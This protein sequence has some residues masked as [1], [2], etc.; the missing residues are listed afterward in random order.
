M[1]GARNGPRWKLT[2]ESESGE[3]KLAEAKPA[4]QLDA[5]KASGVANPLSSPSFADV[6][7]SAKPEDLGLDKPTVVTVGT[8]DNFTYT[9]KVGQKTN[10]DFP[11][12]MTV[13]AQFQKERTPGKDEKPEDK[14]KLDKEFKEKQKKLEEK[15]N[16]EKGYE[17]WVYLVSNW[18]VD[19]MLKE[20]AQLLVEKKEEPKKEEKPVASLKPEE[21]KKEEPKGEDKPSTNEPPKKEDQKQDQ[22]PPADP[23]PEPP[24]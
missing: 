14:D 9:L 16:Q 10:D 24:K 5:S 4:E 20:R 13:S 15:L 17:K 18:T 11:L 7:P 22:P 2:R 6:L 8:F 3:W 19:P 12:A 21:L 1:R 23:K